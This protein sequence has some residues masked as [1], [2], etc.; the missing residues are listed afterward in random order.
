MFAVSPLIA[1]ILGIVAI[2]SDSLRVGVTQFGNSSSYDYYALSSELF[3]GTSIRSRALAVQW[4]GALDC[5]LCYLYAFT[6]VKRCTVGTIL[7]PITISVL[8]LTYFLGSLLQDDIVYVPYC[9]SEQPGLCQVYGT[10]TPC[11]RFFF[12]SS[13]LWLL[14]L[15]FWLQC[16]P[17]LVH[18]VRE[19]RSRSRLAEEDDDAVFSPVL[20][21]CALEL[22]AIQEDDEVTLDTLSAAEPRTYTSTP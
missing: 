14:V 7:V 20:K 10:D 19:W 11:I 15:A 2:H 8:C 17:D 1:W 22:S 6:T 18:E 9:E 16:T 4:L 21:D 5:V 12:A 13:I 3:D